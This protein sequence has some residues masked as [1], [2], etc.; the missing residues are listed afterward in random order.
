MENLHGNKKQNMA[1]V[2]CG[3]DFFQANQDEK[4]KA[5]FNSVT[6]LTEKMGSV[7]DFFKSR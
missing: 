5:L 4:E 2:G 3:S 1:G 7:L 6:N